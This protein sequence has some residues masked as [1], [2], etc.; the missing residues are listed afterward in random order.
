MQSSH[1]LSVFYLKVDQ[2]S[3]TL[4]N[5][6]NFTQLLSDKWYFKSRIPWPRPN[7]PFS[8]INTVR[9][10]RSAH[11]VY[12]PA[13]LLL[14]LRVEH[15]TSP[16]NCKGPWLHVMFHSHSPHEPLWSASSCT[17]SGPWSFLSAMTQQEG[18]LGTDLAVHWHEIGQSQALG[19]ARDVNPAGGWETSFIALI[20]QESFSLCL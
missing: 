2:L 18:C 8:P 1:L 13:V 6:Q 4:E 11:Q 10:A 5:I 3:E 9:N 19:I 20:H 17:I 14:L 12:P 16:S 15:N 7:N